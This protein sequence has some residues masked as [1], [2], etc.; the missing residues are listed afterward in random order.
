MELKVIRLNEANEIIIKKADEFICN[1][2]T[3]GEFINS[4]YYLSYH[5]QGK[6][7][8]DSVAVMDTGSQEI[9]GLCI[10]ARLP[11]QDERI[12]SHPGTTF[13][14]LILNRKIGIKE[15]EEIITLLL[16]YYEKKYREIEIRLRPTIYDVQ[17]MEMIPYFLLRKGY[18]C[19]MMGL[20]NLISLSG[21]R[22]ED[23]QFHLYDSKRRNQV[24]KAIKTEN[25]VFREEPQV[26][27]QY[28]E[29]MN[30]N[31]IKKYHS[32]T[33]H[34]FEEIVCLKKRFPDKIRIY[35]V[36]KKTG[37]YGAFGVIYKF[38]KVFHTQ[39][40][41]LNYV[42]APEYPHLFLIHRLIEQATKQGYHYF[43]F[44][45]STEERG[46]HLNSGL[47][48]Y[49]EGYG[50]GSILLPV[51]IKNNCKIDKT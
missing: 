39:Y 31:L 1:E 16:S 28:W 8:D 45:A 27:R 6:F 44:G 43:S 51:F 14:G 7:L 33:T 37:E 18:Q 48:H 34:S 10:A 40:L 13:S 22:T 24:R 23:D 12:I 32:H 5:P 47:F 19:G 3:N 42:I 21:I 20:A 36:C 46:E 15:V 17:P 9:K 2:D 35:S 49:K 38:K 29:H 41:D 11:G 4:L 30:E 25:F 50:G 26:P